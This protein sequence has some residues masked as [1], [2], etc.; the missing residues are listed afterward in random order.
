M[1]SKTVSAATLPRLHLLRHG[2]TL[3]SITG[4]HTGRT[5]IPLTGMALS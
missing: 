2:E 4:Q 5:D 3:W 1:E